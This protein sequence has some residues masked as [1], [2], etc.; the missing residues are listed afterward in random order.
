MSNY[1]NNNERNQNRRGYNNKKANKQPKVNPNEIKV[2]L[3]LPVDLNDD[4]KNEIYDVLTNTK[5]DKISIPLGIYRSLIED[6]EEGDTR[7]C[8]IGYIRKYDTE[9]TEFTVIVFNKYL[10]IIKELG[11]ENIVLELTFNTYNNTLRTITKF[12]IACLPCNTEKVNNEAE[13]INE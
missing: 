2:P 3:C 10:D 11:M 12:N 6:C 5:F 1:R 4:V 9:S 7:V 8:T 13:T